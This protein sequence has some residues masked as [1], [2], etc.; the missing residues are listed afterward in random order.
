MEL[1]TGQAIYPFCLIALK[2]IDNIQTDFMKK[3]LLQTNILLTIFGL[4]FSIL[5]SGCLKPS[6]GEIVKAVPLP[7]KGQDMVKTLAGE[8][9]LTLFYQAFNRLALA[10][11]ITPNSGFT[12]FAPTDSAMKAAGLD[13]TDIMKLPIDSLRKL[14]MYH[15]ANGVYDDNALTSSI[16]SKQVTT[17][18]QDTVSDIY[19]FRSVVVPPLFIKENKVLYLNGIAVVKSKPAIQ[20]SNGYI[21]PINSLITGIPSRTLYDVIKSDPDLTL[22]NQALIIADSIRDAALGYPDP[23]SED[24]A[25]FSN[26]INFSIYGNN[27]ASFYPTVLAPTNKAFNDAGFHTVNDIRQFALRSQTGFN[28]DYSAFNF[29]PVDSVLKHHILY[30]YKVAQGNPGTF[31]GIIRIFYNDLL[32]PAINNGVYNSYLGPGSDNFGARGS[33]GYATP[34]TFSASNGVVNIKWTSD[35]AS[36]LVVLPLDVSMLHPVNNFIA[37]NGALYKIDKLFYPIVK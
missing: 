2:F 32:N 3:K 11:V 20:T 31:V 13:A 9:S 26:P 17:L 12:I 27:Y 24:V 5:L 33:L 14:I 15:I 22:Y 18:Q 8:S 29:S 35:P 23:T 16:T 25:T 6:D 10:S 28:T 36:P 1:Y 7:F 19:G 21:Y 4:S 30:N 34:L 37:S